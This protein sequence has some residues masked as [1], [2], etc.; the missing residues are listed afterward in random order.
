MYKN[1]IVIFIPLIIIA[2]FG[3]DREL[4]QF[5]YIH[6]D[7]P[8]FDFL[9]FITLFGVSKIYIIV[10]LIGFIYYKKIDENLSKVYL[11]I[12]LSSLISGV[13]VTILKFIF[14][15]SR[16]ILYHT[17]GLFQF[18]WFKYG[19]NINSFPSGHSAT[20]MAVWVGL[21]LIFP[22][23]KYLFISFAILIAVSRI[24][25]D[26]HYLSDVLFGSFIGI[27]IALLLL[28]KMELNFK[29]KSFNPYPFLIFL[30]LFSLFLPLGY[31]PLFDLDE[32]AF[33]EAT[34][35]MLI[36]HNYITTYLN[37]EVR[38]DKPIL[39]YW[40][41]L[42]SFK[43]YGL[44]EFGARFPSALSAV[45]WF[46]AT[47]IFVK[48]FFDKDVAFWSFFLMATTLQI[49]IIAK[50]S[51][52][53]SLLNFTIALSMFNIYLYYSTK[54]EK[55]LYFL[56][57]FIALGTL[58]KGPIAILIPLATSF[59]FFLIQ[60]ELKLFFKALFN[61][62]ALLLFLIIATPWYFAEYLSE[63]D[64]FI[65]GFF[66]KHNINRF[67]IS[68]ESHSGPLFY[69]LIV[70]FIGL[71]PFSSL[72][73]T[74]FR[75]L[76]EKLK[77]PLTLFLFIWFLSVFLFFSFSGTKLP[78]YIIYGYTPL[79]ILMAIEIKRVKNEYLLFLPLSL[80]LSFFILFPDL[81]LYFKDKIGDEK[82]LIFLPYLKF[83]FGLLYKSI[84]F[85]SLTLLLLL[86]IS[87]IDIKK[88]IIAIGFI[89]LFNLNFVIMKA[90]ANLVQQPIEDCGIIAGINNYNLT[91]WK[92]NK[93]SLL[94]R[95]R[96]KA[97]RGNP[98]KGDI[99]VTTI[100]HLKDF[101]KYKIIYQ[102]YA[103]IMIK[104]EEL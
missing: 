16:P 35:E 54:K 61:L 65:K 53:D 49:S 41:Q 9:K 80:F 104:V 71:I 5:I 67:N 12:L 22:K 44:Y 47:F 18:E 43:I 13:I 64:A 33:S 93:P 85:I 78:H 23:H 68:M 94:F 59:L 95:A 69:Y 70:I 77:N 83:E 89:S 56:S 101:K 40:L 42:L 38:F 17:E 39:F 34:R 8:F 52:A 91:M 62:K 6:R 102:K 19:H 15:K 55:Y 29:E 58:T 14:A 45:L 30:T 36:N 50:A 72:I 100:D 76:K 60:R 87:K 2:L 73:L 74:I 84:L 28:S 26:A 57:I 98:Q 79:I 66:L 24:G 25:I 81:L 27:S 51:I 48:R 96:K 97:K 31:L 7:H 90:Y 103:T 37:G 4:S 88:K 99:V 10:G 11:Y 75:D 1:L 3:V 46:F 92:I 86:K 32:G 63:G 82:I 20:A 21:A